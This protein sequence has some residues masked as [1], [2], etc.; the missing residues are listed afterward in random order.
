MNKS[1]L[2]TLAMLLLSFLPSQAQVERWNS[3]TLDHTWTNNLG[4]G[5]NSGDLRINKRSDVKFTMKNA[6]T[7]LGESYSYRIDFDVHGADGSVK[8]SSSYVYSYDVDSNTGSWTAFNKSN[9]NY[10]YLGAGETWDGLVRLSNGAAGDY[11]TMSVNSMSEPVPTSGAEKV[12][13]TSLVS[14][15]YYYD[16]YDYL[17]LFGS[18]TTEPPTSNRVKDHAAPID[19]NV[20]RSIAGGGAWSTLSLPFDL[21]HEQ[22]LKGLG[23][24]VVY[25]E[26]KDVDLEKGYVNFASTTNGMKAGQPYLIQNNGNAVDKIFLTDVVIKRNDVLAAKN[27]RKSTAESHGYYFVGLLEPTQVNLKEPTYNPNGRAV[28][29]ANPTVEGAKQE[30]KRLTSDGTMKAYRAYLVYPQTASVQGQSGEMR[31]INFDN[32]LNDVTSIE[33]VGVD[34]QAVSNRIY[35]LNGRYVGVDAD[36]LSA[37]IYVRNGVKFAVNR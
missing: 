36:Q 3:T 21:T 15:T 27:N 26:F 19:V 8:S 14:L 1:T 11:L 29:V 20:N 32:A 6:S 23:A 13:L 37:G 34:G 31:F 35:D 10:S 24:N 4:A 17:P 12:I 5:V 22:V 33:Q 16:F 28:Y 2:F 18:D 30:L 7:V 9:G 25:A